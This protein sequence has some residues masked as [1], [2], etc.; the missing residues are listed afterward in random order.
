MPNIKRKKKI[1]FHS[2]H[3]KALTGFGK[4]TKNTLKYLQSTGKYEIIE[5]CNGLQKSN[6]NLSVLP[7]KCIGTLPDE[8]HKIKKINQDKGLARSAGYGSETIDDLI[9]EFKPDIYIGAEDIWAFNGYWDKKWWDKINSCIWTTLDS[10]P[11]LPMAV[12]A[13]PKIKNFFTWSS[14]AE[15][16]MNRIGHDHV[17]TL[18]GPIDCSNFHKLP[19]EKR[20]KLRKKNNISEQSFIIGFVF[21]NQLRKSVPNLLDGF[22]KFTNEFPLSK[23]KL[24]LHTSWSEGWDIPSL[25][26]E[27]QINPTSILTT[28]YCSTCKSYHISNFKGSKQPCP[29]CGDKESCNTPTVTSG[30]SETQLNE[31]YNLMD[32]YCHPFTSGGQEIPIQEAKLCELITLVTNYSCGEDHCTPESG[33]LPLDWAEYREP[34]TQF[35]KAST[36]PDSIFKNLRK[37]FNFSNKKRVSLGKKSREFVVNNYSIEKIGSDLESIIDQMDFIDWDFDFSEEKRDPSYIPNEDQSDAEWL[38]DIYKNILKVDLTSSDDGHKYWSKMLQERADRPKVLEYFKKVAEDEN[39][40]IDEAPIK[41]EDFLSNEGKDKRI[42]VLIDGGE[43]NALC[44]NMLMEGLQG[45][46]PGDNIYV[47]CPNNLFDLIEDNPFVHKVIPF[48]PS[49]KNLGFL[50]GYG[51]HEGF[52][53]IAYMPDSLEGNDILYHNGFHKN[54]FNLYSEV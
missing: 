17:K 27:K 44:I 24:L 3:S 45:Q 2:N 29:H 49:M 30:V 25:I 23:A 34:G 5:A 40:K 52:F 7:W 15:K 38:I 53:K 18:H 11:L 14:F 41:F 1:L 26:S 12:S 8:P 47:I 54:E 20:L 4:N 28:Y 35:I 13:A 21:R 36:N 16:E 50:E 42:A 19:D 33:G 9:K 37:V 10:L 43:E 32:V 39:K 22:K 51:S 46:Y 48:T 31:I 6:P